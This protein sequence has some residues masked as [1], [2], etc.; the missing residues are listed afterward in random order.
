MTTTSTEKIDQDQRST[1]VTSATPSTTYEVVQLRPRIKIIN[2]H[3][4]GDTIVSDEYSSAPVDRIYPHIFDEQLP[5][6]QVIVCLNSALN[7]AQSALDAFGVPDFQTIATRFSQI[8]VA[9]AKAHPVTDF[10]E[11]LGAVVSFIRRAMLYTS[12]AEV[13]RSALNSLVKALR[14]LHLNPMLDLDEASDLVDELIN[15]KW[16]G[17]HDTAN[18]LITALLDDYE[19]EEVQTL[20]FPESYSNIKEE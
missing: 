20:L 6:G 5:P 12:P 18:A 16:H 4:D 19:S 13:T 10:N 3:I 17:E 7:D 8:A 15:E 1:S 14:S 2:T 11:S 9:M